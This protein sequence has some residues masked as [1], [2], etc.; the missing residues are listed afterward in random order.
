MGSKGVVGAWLCP[1]FF[2]AGR[3]RRWVSWVG[4]GGYLGLVL[5]RNV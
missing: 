3:L 5:W 2:V 1:F 4:V